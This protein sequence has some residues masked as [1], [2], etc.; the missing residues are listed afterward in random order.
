MFWTTTN[1]LAH[2]GIKGQKWGVMNGPPYPLGSG[3]HSAS[4]KKAGWRSS[5]NKKNKS[6]SLS[7]QKQ[8]YISKQI[9][10]SKKDEEYRKQ[11][12]SDE[13]KRKASEI[14]HSEGFK[15]AM[16]IT[17]IAAGTYV[18]CKIGKKY[19]VNW[20]HGILKNQ[21][22]EITPKFKSLKDI[23]KTTF[24]YADDFFKNNTKPDE[25]LVKG[26]NHGEFE[27]NLFRQQN[28]TFCTASIIARLKG[29]DVT[30]GE[31]ATG[32]YDELMDTWFKGAKHVKI[33]KNTSIG[34]IN[35]LV[36]QG[37]GSYGALTVLW[38]Q[39]GAHELAYAVRDNT[40]T[41]L[42]GQTE[43]IYYGSEITDLLSNCKISKTTAANLTNC[44]LTDMILRAIS[45]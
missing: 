18:A 40:L 30:A 2:H 35:E 38:K 15:K 3:D 29:Y 22:L 13:F 32:Y 25:F 16:T 34:L 1:Y 14:V 31:T 10:A 23:P 28:C 8:N 19:A 5:L 6:N 45:G 26:I 4:E 27:S 37:N 41:I 44:E 33:N 20:V 42:D 9:E 11:L 24:N 17:A 43:T 21:Y 12:F 36:K 7:N 39:G